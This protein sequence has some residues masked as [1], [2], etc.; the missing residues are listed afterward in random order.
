[1]ILIVFTCA[2]IHVPT[3]FCHDLRVT[4]VETIETRVD[5]DCMAEIARREIEVFG[6]VLLGCQYVPDWRVQV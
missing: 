1:M 5:A 6:G 3:M 2:A 4:E